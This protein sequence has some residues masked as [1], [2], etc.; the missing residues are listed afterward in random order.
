MPGR[1]SVSAA[2]GRGRGCS[3]PHVFERFYK[4]AGGKHGIG[5]AIAQSVAETYHGEISVHNDGG[6]VFEVRFH[7]GGENG[8][9]T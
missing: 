6:A 4:G 3:L 9:G 2:V 5:L 8:I 7:A 1:R